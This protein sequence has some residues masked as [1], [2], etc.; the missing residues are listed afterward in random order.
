M[1][2]SIGHMAHWFLLD[3]ETVTGP[4]AEEEIRTRMLSAKLPKHILIWGRSMTSWKTLHAWEKDL[5]HLTA[6][7]ENPASQQLWHY[8]VDGDS[9]G[10]MARAELINEIKNLRSRN[11]ILVWT[12]GMKAWADIYEFHDLLDEI[13]INRR[14][15]PRANIEGSVALKADNLSLTGQLKSI[16]PG[17]FSAVFNES[18]LAIGQVVTAELKSNHLSVGITAKSTVQYIAESGV[19]GFKFQAVNMEVKAHIMEYIKAHKNGLDT[20]A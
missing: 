19:V 4:F 16:S 5:P 15:H 1:S 13:G 14:D 17:G 20:A 2:R 7:L 10:P 18:L 6:S 9:K 11:E 8:A 3:N 12:K